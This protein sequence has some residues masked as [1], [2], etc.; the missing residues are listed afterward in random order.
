MN[1][2]R[3]PVLVSWS[4]GKDSTLAL[5]DLLRSGRYDV[6]ALVTTV[7]AGFERISHHGVRRALLREQAAALGLPLEEV[8]VSQQCTNAE[9]ESKLAAALLPHRERGVT[10]VVFGDIFLEDLREYRER[11]L[12]GFG[13]HGLFPLWKR[14]TSVLVR[15]FLARGF[16]TVTVCVDGRVLDRSFAGRELDEA[17]LAELPAGVDPCGENGEFHTFVFEGP[18]FREP[19]RFARGDVVER[20]TRY[21]CDLV[22]DDQA[23]STYLGPRATPVRTR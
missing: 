16:R 22:L 21:F 4:G 12:A 7:A 3:Q 13:M 9:Y 2:P 15:E 1:D 18:L 23:D 10:T 19:V 11:H 20:D 14:D 6:T 8:V 5:D 17:F